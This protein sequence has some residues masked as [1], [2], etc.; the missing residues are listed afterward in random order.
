[1]GEVVDVFFSVTESIAKAARD[2]G[3]GK[4]PELASIA[5]GTT[6][7]ISWTQL[8]TIKQ[9]AQEKNKPLS[10]KEL[11]HG[12]SKVTKVDLP[13]LRP[14]PPNPEYEKMMAKFR[15]KE[16]QREIQAGVTHYPEERRGIFSLGAT[17]GVGKEITESLT[18][19]GNIVI[20]MLTGFVAFWFVGRNAFGSSE[21]NGIICG[22]VGMIGALLL[23]TW[24]FL[25]KVEKQSMI[26]K[27]RKQQEESRIKMA[28]QRH[29]QKTSESEN[30]PAS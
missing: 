23:E 29:S 5:N 27:K 20:A 3:R 19:G 8:L 7:E 26:E 4:I 21:V 28:M 18:V 6:K 13:S 10:L 9:L 12:A 1:M 14:P 11:M 17:H 24:M 2:H 16:M 15:L 25:M 30:A 22:A